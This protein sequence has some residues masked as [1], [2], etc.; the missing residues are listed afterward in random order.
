MAT[1]PHLLFVLRSATHTYSP[2]RRH[3]RFGPLTVAD[4]QSLTA[5]IAAADAKRAAIDAAAQVI[6]AADAAAGRA[7]CIGKCGALMLDGFS[8]GT[9]SAYFSFREEE[10]PQG[11]PFCEHF[12]TVSLKRVA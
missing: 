9:R 5:R 10:E 1:A 4:D 2:P 6:R 11:E 3:S 8:C 12:F 7:R